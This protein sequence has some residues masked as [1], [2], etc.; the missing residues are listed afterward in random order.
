M[1]SLYQRLFQN[2]RSYSGLSTAPD[3]QLV[4]TNINLEWWKLNEHF[5]NSQILDV[6][7]LRKPETSLIYRDSLITKLVEEKQENEIPGNTWKQISKVCKKT[8]E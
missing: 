4:K 8:A 2:L 3:H 1:K 5:K 7:K 6:D